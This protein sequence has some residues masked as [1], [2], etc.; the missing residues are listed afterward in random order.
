ML[1]S[2]ALHKLLQQEIDKQNV[3]NFV[4]FLNNNA[5]TL[6]HLRGIR[7]CCNKKE[8]GVLYKDQ[9]N[10]LFTTCTSSIQ[11]PRNQQNCY[12]TYKAWPCLTVDRV[13]FSLA[14]VLL[15]N[16]CDSINKESIKA[17]QLHRN[18][19]VHNPSPL[20]QDEFELLWRKGKT[21]LFDVIN[22]ES[23]LDNR[24]VKKL[25][26]STATCSGTC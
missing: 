11:C 17:L 4:D 18:E 25:M 8:Y 13:D 20:D 7:C 26:I 24:Y 9:W 3:G 6:F 10:Y 14:C 15:R 22:D 21:S 1:C 12:H 19:F 23:N 5:E 16:I 2:R